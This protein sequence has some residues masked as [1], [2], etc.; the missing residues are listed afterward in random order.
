MTRRIAHFIDG[1]TAAGEG[2]A[3]V[4]DPS[5][6]VP[7]GIAA[8]AADEEVDAADASTLTT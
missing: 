8:A 3:P 5:T 1:A 6:G 2:E 7:T 4:F